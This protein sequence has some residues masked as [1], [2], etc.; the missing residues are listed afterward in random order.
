MTDEKFCSTNVSRDGDHH[1][2]AAGDKVDGVS[3]VVHQDGLASRWTPDAIYVRLDGGPPLKLT[4][5][6]ISS[7]V[8]CS[9][10]RVCR[11]TA[12]A[13]AKLTAAQWAQ[14]AAAQSVLMA[15]AEGDAVTEPMKVE[16]AQVREWLES[17][18]A[19]GMVPR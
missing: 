6:P 19:E 10:Y 16:A 9:R 4:A 12:S 11:W 15:L 7:D 13:A 1:A 17:L 3:L 2:F 18:A 14:I 5:T 8:H